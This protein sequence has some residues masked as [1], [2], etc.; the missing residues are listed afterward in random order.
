MATVAIDNDE[1]KIGHMGASDSLDLGVPVATSRERMAAHRQRR[2]K[3]LVQFAVAVAAD[4]LAWLARSG[5]FEVQSE[6]GKRAVEALAS[7]APT[8]L[9]AS[10]PPGVTVTSEVGGTITSA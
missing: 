3:N 5:Y 1:R 4:D 10:T 9:P 2:R 7:S 8:L 6:D